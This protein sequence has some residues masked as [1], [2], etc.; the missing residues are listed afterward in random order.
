MVT[1]E[2]LKRF[3]LLA[4]LPHE[5]LGELMEICEIETREEGETFAREGDPVDRL[6]LVLLGKMALDKRIQL[7]HHGSVRRANVSIV[8]PGGAMGWSAL[9]PPHIFTLSGICLEPCKFITLDAGQLRDFVAR[10]PQ[11]GY[12]LM[13]GIAE[14][15]GTRLQDMT[16][17]LTYFLSIVSHELKAPLAAVENYLEVMLGG[18]TGELTPKQQRMLERSVLRIHDLSGLINN[19]LDLARMRPEQ[20]QADFVRFNPREFGDR[21]VED[22]RLAAKEKGVTIKVEAPEEFKD[23]VGAPRQLRQVLTN[24]LNNAIKFSPPGSTVTLRSWETGDEL[25][26]EVRDEGIGIPPEDQ[27][28]IFEDFFR[29]RN[30]GDVGGSGLGL[31]IAKKI[32]DAHQGRILLESPYEKGKSG[33]KFTVVLPR[34]LPLPGE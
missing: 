22:T 7:G 29:A 1:V 14:L 30:V 28:S 2:M 23:I 13:S 24:L 17:M 5:D 11:A 25:R 27:A 12:R 10:N 20:I 34:Y 16:A 31:S 19:L 15:V 21:S 33:T 18:F 4:Y 8:G 9:V 6:R 26:V 32:V 3:P